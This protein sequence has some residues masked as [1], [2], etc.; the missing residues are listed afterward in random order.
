MSP[1]RWSAVG[2]AS[3]ALAG[4]IP[5]ADRAA[6]VPAPAPAPVAQ[7]PVPTPAPAPM[8]A[9]EFTLDGEL[10]QGGTVI[11]TVPE[12][13]VALAF[14]GETIPVAPDRKFLIAFDRDHGPTAVLEATLT[15]GR[16]VTKSLAV[17]PRAWD[18]S[19][20]NRLPKYPVPSEEFKRRRPAELAQIKGAR[21]KETGAKGWRQ[22]FIWPATGRISTRFG[23]QRIYKGGEKG[24]YHSGTDIAVP[25]GTPVRAPADGVVIL[26][27]D[28]P[29]TL[30][31]N[32]LMLDHGMGLNSAFL[33]LSEIDVQPGEHVRR[34]Q[35][36]AQSGA[37]GRATGPH[38]HWS[39]KWRDARIDPSL[40]AGPM[41]D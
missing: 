6:P 11:G 21:A 37:S 38:L 25:V 5:A 18:I 15:D 26:A 16:H 2:A 22:D 8:P 17:A 40:I 36:I 30:G 1:A 7:A 41:P 29:F 13:T 12:G 24:S 10:E 4:C 28:H 23:A 27:T 39:L 34:G 33:H 32:L 31:G 3:L 35:V 14:D 20:L 9:P 19:R